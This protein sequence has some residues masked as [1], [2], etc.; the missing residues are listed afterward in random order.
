MDM[1]KIILIGNVGRDPEIRHLQSGAKVASFSLATNRSW[2]DKTT[3]EKKQET[4]WHTIQ[5]FNEN[6]VKLCEGY[7]RKGSRVCVEGEIR[8]RKYQD[9]DTGADRWMTEILIPPYNGQIIILSG[10][11]NQEP[12]T[13]STADGD[14]EPPQGRKRTPAQ[15]QEFDD[16]IPF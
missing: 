14:Y 6:I 8:Y 2:K 10:G 5:S 12:G 7:I 16:D 9:K 11:K 1:N 15:Q 3:G 4:Q 13:V